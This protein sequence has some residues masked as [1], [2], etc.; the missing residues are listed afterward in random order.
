[1]NDVMMRKARSVILFGSSVTF[2]LILCKAWFL[3]KVI[4]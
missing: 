2:G 1:M 3:M 4:A